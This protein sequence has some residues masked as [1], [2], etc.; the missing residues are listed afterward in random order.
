MDKV[1]GRIFLQ[2]CSHF[3]IVRDLTG[4]AMAL[5]PMDTCMTLSRYDQE[6]REQGSIIH[7]DLGQMDISMTLSRNRE[8][9]RGSNLET[10]KTAFIRICSD[11]NF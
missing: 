11:G 4:G 9:G 7:G 2:I 10:F 6:R 8:L 3:L 1:S 5:A